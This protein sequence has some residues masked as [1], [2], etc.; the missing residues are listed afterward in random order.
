[1]NASIIWVDKLDSTN[2]FAQEIIK[3]KLS[4]FGI[5]I[6]DLQ[7]K[8]K[9]KY[10]KKWISKKGNFFA[11]IFL[12]IKNYKKITDLQY[13][14]LNIL[15]KFFIKKG[16]NKNLVSIK[17][18]N[19]ILINGNKVCGILIESCSFEKKIF[20][21]VGIGINLSSSPNVAEYK[22]T[23]LNKYFKKKMTINE[24]LILLKKTIKEFKK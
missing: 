13:K 3:K 17:E 20:G 16:I 22:T 9:G 10:G 23:F 24:I 12:R 11:S 5:V 6:S 2:N 4:N 19:D 15:L 7:N 18:P 21:F 8:G 14:T 1:M